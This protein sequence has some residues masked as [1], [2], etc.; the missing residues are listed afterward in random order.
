MSIYG[1]DQDFDFA[2][3]MRALDALIP[4]DQPQ[5]LEDGI[6]VFAGSDQLDASSDVTATFG[7]AVSSATPGLA[8]ETPKAKP[9]ANAVKAT[10]PQAQTG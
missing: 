6:L 8:V 1:D 5:V 2:A 9:K 4:I 7:G 10:P 3:E